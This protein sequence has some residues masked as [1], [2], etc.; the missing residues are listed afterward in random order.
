MGV[1]SLLQE[2]WYRATGRREIAEALHAERQMVSHLQESI[3]DLENRM[4]EPGWQQM[5][6]RSQQEF[7]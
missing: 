3:A 2:T 4:R 7:S 6:A 1:T 5:A